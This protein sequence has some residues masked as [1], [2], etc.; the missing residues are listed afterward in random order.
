MLEVSMMAHVLNGAKGKGELLG[1]FCKD[2]NPLLK[3][4]NTTTRGVDFNML[5]CRGHIPSMTSGVRI[6]F[7]LFHLRIERK[8]K[9]F[10]EKKMKKHGQG[11]GSI[12]K[13]IV[14]VTMLV[15]FLS[16]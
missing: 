7:G 14:V 8:M 15:I 9:I 4:P 3:P 16:L 1:P 5:I 6:G 2:T 11:S 13:R 12:W 10:L